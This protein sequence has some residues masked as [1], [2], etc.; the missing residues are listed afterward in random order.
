M[1][2]KDSIMN[3]FRKKPREPSLEEV[4]FKRYEDYYGHFSIFHPKKWKYDPSVVIDEGAYAVVFHS[5]K[6]EALFRIGVETILPLKFDFAKYAKEE[7]EK[8]S[9][10]MVSK[11]CRAKFR[12]YPCYKTDYKYES[13]GKRYRGEKLIFYTGDRVFS[14]FYTYPAEE[15]NLRKIFKYMA[16][17]L[18]IN[19]AKTK[20]FKSPLP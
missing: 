12:K 13:E 1:S 19:P 16:E 14:I 2:I 15:K 17:S 3:I 20:I 6:S 7:I 18:Q 9:S 5:N 11:A 10:G 4:K 8:P